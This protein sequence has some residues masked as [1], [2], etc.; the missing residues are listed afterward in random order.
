MRNCE[1][2]AREGRVEGENEGDEGRVNVCGFFWVGE[3]GEGR[4]GMKL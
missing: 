4:C 2:R 1:I 3:E